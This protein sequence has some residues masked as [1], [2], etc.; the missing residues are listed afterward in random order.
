MDTGEVLYDRM[1]TEDYE[2]SRGDI[3]VVYGIAEDIHDAILNYQV[4]SEKS[5]AIGCN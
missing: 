2:E 1:S 5:Y 3:Q 4:C